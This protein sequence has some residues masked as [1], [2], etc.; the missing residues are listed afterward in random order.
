MCVCVFDN[1]YGVIL[2]QNMTPKYVCVC[3]CLSGMGYPLVFGMCVCCEKAVVGGS[4]EWNIAHMCVVF[5]STYR[6]HSR[7]RGGFRGFPVS[8]S[9]SLSFFSSSPRGHGAFQCCVKTGP[10][11]ARLRGPSKSLAKR[12]RSIFGQTPPCFSDFL[13][14]GRIKNCYFGSPPLPYHHDLVT[15]H[16]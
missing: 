7:E 8:P 14:E 4:E 12:V 9:L 2:A 3:V 5:A 1:S 13:W 15:T 11:P 10:S 6:V 16:D